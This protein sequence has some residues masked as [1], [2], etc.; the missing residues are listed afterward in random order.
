M[1][2]YPIYKET[3]RPHG[4][5]LGMVV[6]IPSCDQKP[7]SKQQ[8]LARLDVCMGGRVA[9]EIIFGPEHITS[10]ASS[11]L[12]MATKTAKYMVILFFHI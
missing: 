10:G 6:E 2:A 5:A 8:L 12:H 3:I 9:K 4:S 11:D 1:G 7:I